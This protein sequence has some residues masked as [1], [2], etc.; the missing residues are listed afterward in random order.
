[1][2]TAQKGRSMVEMLGVL[3]IIGILSAGALAGYSK[4]M[5]KIKINKLI[6]QI[7]T[8]AMNVQTLVEA[9]IQKSLSENWFSENRL[10]GGFIPSEMIRDGKIWTPFQNEVYVNSTTIGDEGISFL[11]LDIKN[12][13]PQ[14]CVDL[15]SINWKDLDVSTVWMGD[16][17]LM[18]YA[19]T[20]SR[21]EQAE[22]YA[23]CAAGNEVKIPVPMDIASKVCQTCKEEC[24]FSL[25]WNFG[26]EL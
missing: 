13:S 24:Y 25:F 17:V 2:K 16:D 20:N 11:L 15:S 8:I 1:M 22:E 14:V 12:V 21:E 18:A 3:A 4:A 26:K 10:T 7:S 5:Y 19:C 23:V 6:E 9:D